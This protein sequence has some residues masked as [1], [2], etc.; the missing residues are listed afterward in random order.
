MKLTL[1]L[2]LLFSALPG[3]AGNAD[4]AATMGV[5]ATAAP[6][7][8]RLEQELTRK[9]D[10][11]KESRIPPEQ[12][13]EWEL[14]FRAE[15]DAVMTQA[16]PSSDN[17][18]THARITARLGEGD[19][20]RAALDRALEG[21]PDSPVLIRTKGELLHEQK[22]F[23]GAAQ[24]GLQAW[25]KSGRTDKAAWAL[26][27]MSK[28]RI[29]PS[30]VSHSLTAGPLPAPQGSAAVSA[31]GAGKS[32]ALGTR[33][34]VA[35][36]EVPNPGLAEGEP[37]QRQGGFP[38]WPM[39]VSIAAALIGY[40][41]YR[42]AKSTAAQGEPGPD[43]KPASQAG[44]QLVAG[45]L[46]NSARP[47]PNPAAAKLVEEVLR[48][49]GQQAA[50]ISLRAAAISTALVGSIVIAGVVT[51]KGLDQMIEAQ[52]KYNEAI[53]THRYDQSIVRKI[54]D[55]SAEKTLA[56]STSGA[57]RGGARKG[58]CTPPNGYGN[59]GGGATTVS[60]AL[61]NAELWLGPGYKKIASG[62]YRSADGTRQFRM[63]DDDLRDP[64]QGPHCHFESIGPNGRKIL[65]NSHVQLTD[66]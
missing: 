10:D 45:A 26:Y 25:E 64:A 65:E 15:L 60:E 53:D 43:E 61:R 29:S 23:P 3:S 22:D 51:I 11:R 7:L 17:T 16:P 18:A 34:S 33:K 4:A 66:Q 20:A 9:Q 40:G 21:D 38:L 47:A 39:A 24:H 50:M 36:A 31:S 30:G 14:K 42:G 54:H 62:V 37:P 32:Y 2:A 44:E 12:Y 35:S 52:D 41:G 49:A 63:T 27:Q 46:L 13:R 59:I 56:R 58:G 55:D 48:K 5:D 1:T 8:L 57:G 6:E 19:Q 28:D